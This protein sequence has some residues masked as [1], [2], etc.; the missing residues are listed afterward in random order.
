MTA[1]AATAVYFSNLPTQYLRLTL[2]I[3]FPFIII[4]IFWR[5]HPFGKAFWVFLILFGLVLIWWLLIP[6]SNNRQWHPVSEVLC[7]ADINGDDV[8]IHNIRNF[9]YRSVTDFTPQ[10]YDKTFSLSSLKTVDLYLIY[11]GPTLIAH[12]IMSFGFGEQ[13]YVSISIETRKEV[14]E[15]YSA[16]KGFFK[17]YELI[18]MVGD[19]RDLVRLRTHIKNEDVYLYRL[20]AE[21]QVIRNIFLDYFKTI[22]RLTEK[23]KWYNALTHNCTTTIRGHALPHTEN[24]PLDWR[25]IVNG[26]LDEMLYERGDVDTSLPFT[27]LK[28]QVYINKKAVKWDESQDYSNYIRRGLP[29]M[30]E[31][32]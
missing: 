27:E 5:V 8:T 25:L 24:R 14:G 17:Q 11:W 29:G 18:Y 22:N 26:F 9:D 10:Y 15:E 28:K 13:G 16:I 3:L 1:W 23:P 4:A 2:S 19:E 32:K 21:P 30:E 7:Y 31:F 6:P 12:T 20:K